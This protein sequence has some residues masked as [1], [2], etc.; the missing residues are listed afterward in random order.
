MPLAGDHGPRSDRGCAQP[1]AS[2]GAWGQ[3]ARSVAGAGPSLPLLGGGF[4][5]VMPTACAGRLTGEVQ[6]VPSGVIAEL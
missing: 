5:G 1:D 4:R 3:Q 2:V 6:V